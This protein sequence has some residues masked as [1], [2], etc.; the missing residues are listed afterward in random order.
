LLT[1]G[2]RILVEVKPYKQ[3]IIPEGEILLKK[4]VAEEYA[5][6]NNCIYAFITE[7][8]MKYGLVRKKLQSL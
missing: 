6:K 2:K 8:D 3:C 4:K 7:K 5:S 1:S